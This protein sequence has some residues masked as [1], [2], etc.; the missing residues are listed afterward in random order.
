MHSLT[1]FSLATRPSNGQYGSSWM[2]A[3]V[4]FRHDAERSVSE[5]HDELK[6]YIESPLEDVD[7]ENVVAWWG[8]SD[9]GVIFTATSKSAYTKLQHHSI[10][11]PTLAR[12]ARDYLAIQGLAT[13]SE[14]A[15]S[16]GGTTGTAKRNRLTPEAFEALQLLK[17]AYRNGHLA[18]DKEAD[19]HSLFLIDFTESHEDV[20]AG[21]KWKGKGRASDMDMLD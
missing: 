15:F 2:R 21:P 9:H 17:S 20:P 14:R 1:I 8:V 16:S 10:Q 11:Y 4:Q 18:A 5:P 3:A 12:I 6:R 13:P 7:S 19:K